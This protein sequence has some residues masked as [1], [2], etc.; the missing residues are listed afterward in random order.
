MAF[1]KG[2]VFVCCVNR[3][4]NWEMTPPQRKGR[5]LAAL[6]RGHWQQQRTRTMTRRDR[7]LL[8]DEDGDAA[9]EEAVAP[10]DAAAADEATGA[11]DDDADVATARHRWSPSPPASDLFV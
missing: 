5:G 1:S 9:V 10:A 8:R 11:A 6:G 7:R 3:K 4:K 2:R